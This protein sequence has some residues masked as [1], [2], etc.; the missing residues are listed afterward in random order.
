MEWVIIV[1]SL[2]LVICLWSWISLVFLFWVY[3]IS[4]CNHAA[5][6]HSFSL[7]RKEISTWKEIMDEWEWLNSELVSRLSHYPI[8]RFGRW[9][10]RT[11]L[12]HFPDDSRHDITWK[13]LGR[14]GKIRNSKGLPPRGW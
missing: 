14:I 1:L 11:G 10:L 5:W 2:I 9:V 8:S 6:D 13:L 4:F 3:S 7:L 12:L